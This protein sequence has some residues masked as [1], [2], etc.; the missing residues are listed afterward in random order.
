M[1]GKKYFVLHVIHLFSWFSFKYR[2]QSPSD[3]ELSFLN[4]ARKLENYGVDLHSARVRF[5]YKWVGTCC[6]VYIGIALAK[7]GVEMLADWWLTTFCG[8]ILNL[9]ALCGFIHFKWIQI[10]IRIYILS[11]EMYMYVY[12]FTDF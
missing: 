8:A 4:T 10:F 5:E 1:L 7:H 11:S 12:F 6:F 2:G 3:A 9:F